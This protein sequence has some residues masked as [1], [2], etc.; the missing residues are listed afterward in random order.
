M[1]FVMPPAVKSAAAVIC[2]S[3]HSKRDILKAYGIECGKV[4]V[5]AYGVEHRRF[6]RGALLNRQ[7][8]QTI[9][10]RNDGYV[11]HVGAFSHRKNIPTLLRAIS[12]LRSKGKWDRQ[13]VLAGSKTPGL[14]GSDEIHETIRQLDLANSVVPR[15]MC[16]MNTLLACTPMPASW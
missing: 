7:W 8:A 5:V 6:H 15:V 2:G 11:L 9:G 1:K 16:P 10:I 13:L 14:T 4:H 3:E 12:N